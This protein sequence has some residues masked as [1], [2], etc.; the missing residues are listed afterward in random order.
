MPVYGN[1][2]P[3]Y[4]LTYI[5]RYKN[6]AQSLDRVSR[7]SFVINSYTLKQQTLTLL[8]RSVSVHSTDQFLPLGPS[9]LN[10]LD[11]LLTLMGCLLN[12]RPST[13]DLTQHLNAKRFRMKYHGLYRM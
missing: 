10:R 12:P 8:D 9:T 2:I 6:I 7:I 3:L 1:N 4:K 13:I 11:Q 5:D